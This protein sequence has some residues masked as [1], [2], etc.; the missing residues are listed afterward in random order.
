[1][2]SNRH[3]DADTQPLAPLGR[4]GASP[5]GDG[6]VWLL[7]RGRW[8][9]TSV[10]L[11]TSCTLMVTVSLFV[12]AIPVNTPVDSAGSVTVSIRQAGALRQVASAAETVAELLAEQDIAV[13]AGS[14]LFP[15]AS[16]PLREGLVV[17]IK[18]ARAVEIADN[19]SRLTVLTALENPLEILQQADIA[20]S[21]ADKIW[22]NGA[23]AD[24]DALPG[25][26]VPAKAIRIRRALQLTVVDDGRAATILSKAETVGDALFAAGIKLYL[27]DEV[28]PPLDSPVADALTISIK[29]AIPVELSL[30]GVVIEA[31]TNAERVADVLVELNAPLFGLDYVQPPGDTAVSAGMRIEILRVTEEVVT[32]SEAIPHESRLQPD[33]E[34][35]LDQSALLQEGNDGRREI[36]SRVRYENGLEVSRDLIES[37]VAEAPVNRIVAYG[38]RVV[39]L[40]TINTPEGPR[41]YWRRLCMYTTSYNPSSNGGN[42][43]TSTG[44][45]LDKGVIASKPNIIPYHTRVFVPNYG[46]GAILDTGGGPSGTDYWVDLGYG[47][48]DGFKPWRAYTWVYHLMPP[49]EKINYRLPGWTPNSNWTGNC[50]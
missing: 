38:T 42:L 29:R 32:I 18:P 43:R 13:P 50:G 7:A 44:A 22:V 19:G 41:Q 4:A 34:M 26:T 9:L 28:S 49:P 8:L 33:A 25:W 46:N 14:Q 40:G 36:R 11:V 23:L 2:S 31:R 24:Y 20:L 27:T 30:D 15:P 1:M 16:E 35:N 48:G 6:G 21:A 45:T 3:S 12:R 39:P 5:P 37:V 17:S 47:E 10:I